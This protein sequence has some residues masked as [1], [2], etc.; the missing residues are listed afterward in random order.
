[1]AESRLLTVASLARFLVDVMLPSELRL[2][3]TGRRVETRRVFR[4]HCW[5][6]L[7]SE[8]YAVSFRYAQGVKRDTPHS[9][10]VGLSAVAD[11]GVRAFI[12]SFLYEAIE[13]SR[14]NETDVQLVENVAAMER[15]EAKNAVGGGRDMK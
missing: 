7:R 13:D 15:G 3:Q 12:A 8:R 11:Q 14:R 6:P 10:A 5:A 1:M 2:G 9:F 4:R